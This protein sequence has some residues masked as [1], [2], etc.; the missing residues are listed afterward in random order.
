M[1]YFKDRCREPTACRHKGSGQHI[2]IRHGTRGVQQKH[3]D[4][5]RHP[6]YRR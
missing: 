4:T 1:F 5:R 3:H 2:E 6:L